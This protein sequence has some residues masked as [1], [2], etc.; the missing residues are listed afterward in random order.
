LL[1]GS[2]LVTLLYPA[3]HEINRDQAA[4]DQDE[5]DFREPEAARKTG[6]ALAEKSPETGKDQCPNETSGEI[7]K[8]KPSQVHPQQPRGHGSRKSEAVKK[9]NDEDRLSSVPPDKF[10][11]FEKAVFSD[12]RQ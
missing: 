7:E 12:E 10:L 5:S 3:V 2:S 9:T 8:E 11:A 6:E 1:R 4:D